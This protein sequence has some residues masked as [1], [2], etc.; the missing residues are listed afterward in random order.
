MR[1]WI[2]LGASL[3]VSGIFLWLALRDVP[4]ADVVNGIRQADFTWVL[5]SLLCIVGAQASR[6]VRWR[7]LLG[8]RIAFVQ[9]LHILNVTM[10]LNQLPLRAG[11]VARSLLATRSNVPV[12][13][14]ATSIVVE[15]LMDVV[16]VVLFLAF[17]LTRLPSAP[18]AVTQT[19][20]LFGIAGVVSFIVLIIFARYPQAAHRLLDWFE[21]HLPVV[22]RLH[23]RQRVDEV[24]EGLRPLTHG[25]RAAQAFGWTIIGWVFSVV[26]FYALERALGIQGVD[27]ALGAMLGVALASFSIA[28]PVTLAALGPFEGAVRIAGGLVN[29]NPVTATTLGFLFHGVTVLAYGIV[30]TIGLVTLGISLSDV[31]TQPASTSVSD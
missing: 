31:L 7:G 18:A 13:T 23:L 11:E 8:Y 27:L 20:V 17:A 9:T 28:I 16:T 2:V 12:V 10:L 24:L 15:R 4:L 1:R 25:A 29:M 26:T 5:V 30:G 22:K 3:L 21:T 14:A 19:A 6:A